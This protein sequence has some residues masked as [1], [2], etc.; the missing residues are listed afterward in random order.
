MTDGSEIRLETKL[1]E[2]V[3]PKSSAPPP[4][5]Q[6]K[7]IAL[8]TGLFGVATGIAVFI[9]LVG[10]PEEI[11]ITFSIFLLVAATLSFAFE[12][13]RGQID[14]HAEKLSFSRILTVLVMLMIFELFVAAIH[15]SFNLE[16][17]ALEDIASAVA[18]PAL[19]VRFAPQLNLVLMALLWV[20]IGGI[21]ALALSYS[22]Y[23]PFRLSSGLQRLTTEKR[24]GWAMGLL[25]GVVGAPAVVL[26]YIL[27]VRILLELIFMMTRPNEWANY[28]DKLGRYIPIP[29][30]TRVMSWTSE[31]WGAWG[32]IFA[33]VLSALILFIL[34]KTE[35]FKLV[36]VGLGV[37]FAAPLA[38]VGVMQDLK[39]IGLILAFVSISWSFV[40]LILGIMVP[41][42][43]RWSANPRQ[44]AYLSWAASLVMVMFAAAIRADWFWVCVIFAILFFIAGIIMRLGG[45]PAEYWTIATISIA[46]VI[47]GSTHLAFKVNFFNISDLCFGLINEQMT[48][49]EIWGQ[50]TPQL[51]YSDISNEVKTNIKSHDPELYNQIQALTEQEKQRDAQSQK[52]AA[53]PRNKIRDNPYLYH[54]VSALLKRGYEILEQAE[55]LSEK[56]ESRRERL[57]EAMVDKDVIK[58]MATVAELEST[59][60]DHLAKKPLNQFNITEAE[61]TT[62]EMVDASKSMLEE[63]RLIKP[64]VESS[65]E[66][67]SRTYDSS[68]LVEEA[69]RQVAEMRGET[70]DQIPE[71]LL[72]KT[73][74]DEKAQRLEENKT[75]LERSSKDLTNKLKD[76]KKDMTQQFELCV[77]GS[78]GFWIAM[79]IL[80]TWA[81]RNREQSADTEGAAS[82]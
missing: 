25:A 11:N 20:L 41:I 30:L 21:L 8:M 49:L 70:P 48:A 79:G 80:A 2:N 72:M 35:A 53:M 68:S 77:A 34:R 6:A 75:K 40:G 76:E 14:G 4:S 62:I 57:E 1:L 38:G 37:V 71:L 5:S 61:M 13:I 36:A 64:A 39:S 27:S 3:L 42:L 55:I 67:A 47:L 69:R 74:L 58:R 12:Y 51:R 18:G 44:W 60:R 22:I 17:A 9:L 54:P 19:S 73:S 66:S 50:Q 31:H 23:W 46:V 32:V 52:I 65:M 24:R 26:T 10:K 63:L 81:N 7:F 78:L 33:L 16:W 15:A 82:H 56:L 28:L 43:N 59:T 29:W 45:S